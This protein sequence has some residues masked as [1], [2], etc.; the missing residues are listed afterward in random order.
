MFTKTRYFFNLSLDYNGGCGITPDVSKWMNSIQNNAVDNHAYFEPK[1]T[2]TTN[3]LL[4]PSANMFHNR[5]KRSTKKRINDEIR[6]TC[7]LSI[8]TDPLL[9]RHIRQSFADVS[10]HYDSIFHLISC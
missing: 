4:S 1:S 6:N 7:S 5:E 8:Q 3:H 10:L 2:F 9:W